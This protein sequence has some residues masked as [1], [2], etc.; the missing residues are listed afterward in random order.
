MT[1]VK[2]FIKSHKTLLIIIGIILLMI[3]AVV[4]TY[5][6]LSPDSKK[7]LYGNRLEEIEKHPI[8]ETS[9]SNMQSEMQEMEGITAISYNL[10]GKLI[11]IIITLDPAV[12]KDTAV[13]YANKSLEYFSEDV[14]TYY[15]IQVFLL[16]DGESEIYP[17]IGY[18]HKTSS[19]LVWKQ[20]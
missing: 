10:K 8:E 4:L 19:G 5:L 9:V 17:M 11:N 13:W 12:L 15:D 20:E 6:K 7:D 18:K 2:K 16:T 14:K 3:L 1:N